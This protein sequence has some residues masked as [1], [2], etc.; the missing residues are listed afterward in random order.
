MIQENIPAVMIQEIEK[1]QLSRDVY[2]WFYW[3]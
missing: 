2:E 3:Q 1:E